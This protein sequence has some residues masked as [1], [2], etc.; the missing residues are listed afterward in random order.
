MRFTGS[1]FR[2]TALCAAARHRLLV[3]FRGSEERDIF[4]EPTKV[5][6]EQQHSSSAGPERSEGARPHAGT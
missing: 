3:A 2:A 4:G 5:P 1:H 6:M